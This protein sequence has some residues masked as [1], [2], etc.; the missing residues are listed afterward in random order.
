MGKQITK[1]KKFIRKL[2]ILGDPSVNR[3]FFLNTKLIS[4]QFTKSSKN[5]IGTDIYS[6]NWYLAN[7]L[8]EY[9]FSISDINTAPEFD[10]T[11]NGNMMGGAGCIIIYD[12]T[13]P[14]IILHLEK[15]IL[16]TI[17]VCGN[18]PILLLGNNYQENI[19]EETI[20]DVKAFVTNKEDSWN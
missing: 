1:V 9:K 5:T 13:L 16:E 17:I 7:E 3:D 4:K 2:I 19:L 18:I 6:A 14:D 8:I 11:L 10:K 12:Y 20:A 15:W